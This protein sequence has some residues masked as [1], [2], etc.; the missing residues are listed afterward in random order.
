MIASRSASDA[1]CQQ[2]IL[3]DEGSLGPGSMLL[4]RSHGL[5]SVP[6]S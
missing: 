6:N 1:L 4:V 2:G 5:F 3:F